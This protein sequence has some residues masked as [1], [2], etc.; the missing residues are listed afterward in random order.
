MYD[1][2]KD[3]EMNHHL[4]L[5]FILYLIGMCGNAAAQIDTSY[6]PG[7]NGQILIDCESTGNWS[8]EHDNTSSGS[9]DIVNG[10][11]NN[12]VQLNWD[13]STGDWVQAKYTFPQPIDISDK[14]IFG[15]SLRGSTGTGNLVSL[16][17]ADING[18]F[19]GMDFTNINIIS[20]WMIN[21]PVP[22]KMF[23]HFFTI[24]PNPSLTGIDWSRINRFF[25]AVKRPGPLSGGGNGR[26]AVDH[27]QA[28]RAADW[29]RPGDFDTVEVSDRTP[30]DNAVAYVMDQQ[31]SRT[32]LYRSWKEEAEPKAYLYDQALV[33]ILLT[34][35][36]EWINGEPINTEALRA[37]GLA[38]SLNS[39]QYSDGHWPRAWDL[40]TDTIIIDDEWVGDQAWWI[41]ALMQY[42]NKSLNASALDAA[43]QGAD[44][45]IDSSG[46]AVPSAE[47]TVDIWWALMSTGHFEEA[48][49]VR[50]YLLSTIWDDSLKYW[51]RG[52]NDP[53][54]AMDAA[55]WIGEF[56]RTD[57]VGRTDM[58][59]SALGFVRRTLITADD[60][61]NYYGFD[62]MGPVSI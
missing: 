30:V 9:L 43:Y 13:L 46:I 37:D 32:G 16:M 6:L 54:V 25:V 10:I 17:F 62:G 58:A 44:W 59:K 39:Y 33:L 28:D 26:L 14:D 60:T 12:A 1:F 45:I 52:N 18:V 24:P 51:W 4:F 15:V 11:I 23:Y 49:I 55:T 61:Y 41:T 38:A 19:F 22:K 2:L 29:A 40:N 35:E 31:N 7:W 48:G 53:V 3:I 20:R 8:V 27:L 56:A 5:L 47:G 36:G 21:L 50:D 42:Y 34:R 57:I